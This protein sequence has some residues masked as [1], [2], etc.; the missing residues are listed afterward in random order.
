MLVGVSPSHED[1]STSQLT[2]RP[3]NLPDVEVTDSTRID[4]VAS[5]DLQPLVDESNV[6]MRTNGTTSDLTMAPRRP[7][8]HGKSTGAPRDTRINIDEVRVPAG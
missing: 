8:D 6:T 4:A 3:S 2:N 1:L 7:V 5:V